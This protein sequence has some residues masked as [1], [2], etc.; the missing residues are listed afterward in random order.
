MQY[1]EAP[2]VYPS[3]GDYVTV[4]M[5]GGITGCPDWQWTMAKLLKDTEL[6]VFNPRRANF[7]IDDPD[8]SYEQISWEHY[9]LHRAERIMFWFPAENQAGCPIALFELGAW[10]RSDKHVAVGVEPGY[11]REEDVRIQTGLERPEITVVS[12]LPDLALE[13]RS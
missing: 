13:I 2:E 6:V 11:V 5:A 8:A 7:P 9:H 10:L 1:V 3:G 12:T 4:F